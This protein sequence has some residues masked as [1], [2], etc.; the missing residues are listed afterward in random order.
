MIA[1]APATRR[2]LSMLALAA[3]QSVHAQSV[4]DVGARAAPQVHSYTIAAPSNTTVREFSF[5]LF[6]VVPFS[7]A[8]AVDVGTSYARSDVEHTTSGTTETSDIDGLT[9][10]Q[11]RATYVIG[12]DFV[13]LTAG[14]NLP[15]GQSRVTPRQ[16]I[17]AGLI[18]SDFLAFPISSMGTG[19]G[20]TGGVAVARSVGVWSIGGGVSIHRT[21]QY[22]PFDGDD[23]ATLHYRPGNEY[24]ARVGAD[25]AIGA[26][27][28]TFGFTYSTFGNDDLAGSIYNTGNRYLTQFSFDDVAGPGRLT[29]AAWNL[30]RGAGTMIDSVFIGRENIANAALSY[31]VG[32][33]GTLLEPNIEGRAWSQSNAPTSLLSTVG[34]RAQLSFVGMT[35]LPGV[36]LTFGRVASEASDGANGTARLTGWHAT[37]A[38]RL[39]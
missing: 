24:R 3:T 25:R 27:R 38:V 6:V 22:D 34:V 32:V 31:G 29:V 28:A 18:G 12:N 21:A 14:I 7:P 13:V 2:L 19:L 5:P 39:R 35:M 11:V 20:G 8:L 9:D 1:R 37:L 23:G 26:G 36:G 4:E 17:A 10:T 30:F 16:Q 15:T 33:G